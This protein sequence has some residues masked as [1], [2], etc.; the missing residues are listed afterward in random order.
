MVTPQRHPALPAKEQPQ[1]GRKAPPKE[2]LL[3]KAA[4]D[5]ELG[6]ASAIKALQAGTADAIQQRRALD[7]ILKKAC[8]LPEWPY[9]PGDANATHVHLGRQL[10]GHMIMKLLQMNMA[11]AQRREQN[12]DEH[13]PQSE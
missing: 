6:D 9:V 10:A 3:E 11:T 1:R 8:A 4:N 13:E 5:W 7:W 12:A 2:T